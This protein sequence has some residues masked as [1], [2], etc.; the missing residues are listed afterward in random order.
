MCIFYIAM[1]NNYVDK[2]SEYFT[3]DKNL[4]KFTEY[5]I[6][7]HIYLFIYIVPRNNLFAYSS[8]YFICNKTYSFIQTCHDKL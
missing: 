1:D 7:K 6:C 4:N 2:C 3:F 8:D 5:I